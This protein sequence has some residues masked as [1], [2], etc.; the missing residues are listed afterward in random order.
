MLTKRQTLWALP[1]LILLFCALS[2]AG[3]VLEEWVQT[4]MTKLLPVL[5][6]A[7]VLNILV[8]IFIGFSVFVSFGTLLMFNASGPQLWRQVG[9]PFY[10]L[11]WT[12]LQ[13]ATLRLELEL[14]LEEADLKRRAATDNLSPPANGGSQQCR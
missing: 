11:L 1:L 5:V 6:V 2:L 14:D 7:F 12:E 10:Y 9:N 13:E 8:L 3:Y 4:D